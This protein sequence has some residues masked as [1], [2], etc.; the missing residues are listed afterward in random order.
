MNQAE[1]VPSITDVSCGLCY[2]SESCSLQVCLQIFQLLSSEVAPAVWDKDKWSPALQKI[3][4]A[5][6]D[7]I[8]GQVFYEF[9]APE[10]L[11]RVKSIVVCY[12]WSIPSVSVFCVAEPQQGHSSTGGHCCC[13]A[14]Q[15][16][17]REQRWRSRC[18]EPV[19]DLS[20][21]FVSITVAWQE[22]IMSKYKLKCACME[23]LFSLPSPRCCTT[24]QT[25]YSTSDSDWPEALDRK[26]V[27][28]VVPQSRGCWLL[29]LFRCS[30][31]PQGRTE[32][33]AWLWPGA[34]WPAASPTFCSVHMWMLQK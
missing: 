25:S 26:A 19:T 5:L 16:N 7:I 10:S 32:S 22:I 14:D 11:I 2:W 28:P 30:A 21:R 4:Q 18:M 6:M 33:T 13:H 29:V 34:S 27:T 24:S 8:I 9:T 31:T 1:P 3:L 23:M 20:C 17:I 15:H 12:T